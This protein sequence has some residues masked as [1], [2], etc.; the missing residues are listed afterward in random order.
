MLSVDDTSQLKGYSWF[1]M[2]SSKIKIRF[3]TEFLH[4]INNAVLNDLCKFQ[5]DI[6]IN[7]RVA[8][9]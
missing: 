7:A 5:V 3:L 2:T 4:N 1:A 8:A 9:V 6:P